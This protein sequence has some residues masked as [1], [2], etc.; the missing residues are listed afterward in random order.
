[1]TNDFASRQDL[2][3]MSSAPGPMTSELKEAVVFRIWETK[4]IGS[5]SFFVWADLR[6]L[7]RKA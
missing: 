3:S 6:L 2:F 5:D 1:M 4:H 7:S